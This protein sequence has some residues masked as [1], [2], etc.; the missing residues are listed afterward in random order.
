[1]PSDAYGLD[2]VSPTSAAPMLGFYSDMEFPSNLSPYS[3]EDSPSASDSTDS[4]SSTTPEIYAYNSDALSD[5][6]YGGDR[7]MSS[8]PQQSTA[9]VDFSRLL[10]VSHF[11]LFFFSVETLF[12]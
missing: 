12:I 8:L 3:S 5:F 9:V 10:F 6:D 1:M 2:D 7:P 11:C 4:S